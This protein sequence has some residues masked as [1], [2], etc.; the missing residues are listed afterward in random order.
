MHMIKL[1]FERGGTL[2]A[3]LNDKAPKT[4]KEVMERLPITSTVYHTRWCGREVSFEIRTNRLPPLENCS[5]IVSKF[6][7]A[8]WRDWD[9]LTVPEGEGPKEAIAIYYGPEL[10]RYHNGSLRA[11]IIGRIE[12]DQEQLLEDIGLRIWEYGKEKVTV[13]VY[14]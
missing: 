2:L 12:V 11:N 6:D 10:L 14:K 4:V 1:T 13:E 3:R 8:Y 7:L 5:T 9:G